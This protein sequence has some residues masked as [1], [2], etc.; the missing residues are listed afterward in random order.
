[1]KYVT[2]AYGEAKT[3]MT[4]KPLKLYP[5]TVNNHSV[6]GRTISGRAYS[7]VL[8]SYLSDTIVFAPD[9]LTPESLAH[10]KEWYK[11]SKKYIKIVENKD[12]TAGEFIEV[13]CRDNNLPIDYIDEIDIFP[14][15]TLNIE[16]VE[17]L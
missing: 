15:V 6:S 11:S 5:P 16:Y 17:P 3:A 12:D 13:I 4:L 10:V 1:M 8:H 7:H 9:T 14:E 2:L